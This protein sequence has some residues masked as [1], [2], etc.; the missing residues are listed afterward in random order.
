MN[1]KTASATTANGCAHV[2]TKSYGVCENG[3]AIFQ[4]KIGA[5][6]AGTRKLVKR[7]KPAAMDAAE[8]DSPTVEC[9]QPNRNP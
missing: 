3:T 1:V 8:L 9:I 4:V 7:A 2:K 6:T 5:A